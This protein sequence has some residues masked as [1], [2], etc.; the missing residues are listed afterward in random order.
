M[1]G[2][3][4]PYKFCV[5]N[6]S[7]FKKHS[8]RYYHKCACVFS[9]VSLLLLGFDVTIIFW[10]GF[11]KILECQFHDNRPIAAQLFHADG[12]T[13]R[14]DEA[15]SR[16]SQFCERARRTNCTFSCYRKSHN[17]HN[18]HTSMS[19]AEFEPAFPATSSRRTE[20]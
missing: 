2:F 15:N 11:R 14:H 4:F 6:I 12:Q 20:H 1:C 19:S 3:G 13:D 9:E 7:Y 8:A 16:L 10:S 5:K 17:N 18:R